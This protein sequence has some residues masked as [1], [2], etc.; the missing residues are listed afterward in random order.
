MLLESHLTLCQF[1]LKL[2]RAS[3]DCLR[4]LFLFVTYFFEIV[5]LRFLHCY[6][7]ICN[8]DVIVKENAITLH[9]FL[10]P[11]STRGGYSWCLSK[12]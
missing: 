5:S 9:C 2:T 8:V 10:F 6:S 3:V 7:G 4:V 11:V 12:H 1:V